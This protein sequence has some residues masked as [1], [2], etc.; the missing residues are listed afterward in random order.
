MTDGCI[1]LE[2]VSRRLFFYVYTS[3]LSAFKRTLHYPF[4]TRLFLIKCFIS[5]TCFNLCLILA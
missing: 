5:Y 1:L 2:L 4:I 3:G